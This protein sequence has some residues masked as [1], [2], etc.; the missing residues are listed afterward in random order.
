MMK[1]HATKLA[2]ALWLAAVTTA[3]AGGPRLQSYQAKNHL[4]ETATVCGVVV[5]TKY[6]ASSYRSPTF[7]DLD[8]PYPREPFTIVI[9]GADR[10]KFGTP[11]AT[12]TGERVCVTGPIEEYRGRPEI[13]ATDPAQIVAQ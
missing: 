3:Y 2:T 6:S 12:Y 7:L 8:N 4:H 13:I 10:A 11:E 9:W 1:R 5:S